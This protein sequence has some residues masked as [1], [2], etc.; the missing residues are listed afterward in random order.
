MDDRGF[1]FTADATLALVIV[2]V[3]TGTMTAYSLLPVYQSNEHQHLEAIASSAL[4]VMEQDGTLNSAAVDT[5]MGNYNSARGNLTNRL[6]ALIP[7]GISYRLSLTDVN[8]LNPPAENDSSGSSFSPNVATKVKV[9]SAPN[10]GWMG[11]AWF[12]V[13]NFTFVTQP[14][15]VTSTVW[16][17]HNWLDKFSPWTGG[18][19]LGTYPYWTGGSAAQ[20]IPFSVPG[21]TFQSAKF[22]VGDDSYS[23]GTAAGG[24]FVLNGGAAIHYN[25]NQSVFVGPRS[26]DANQFIWNYQGNISS[27]NMGATNNFY[28]KSTNMSAHKYD[29][30]WASIIASYST[31]IVVPQGILFNSSAYFPD[32]AGLAVQNPTNLTGGNSNSQYQLLYNLNSGNVTGNTYKRVVDWST[33]YNNDPTDTNGNHYDNG[34]PFVITNANYNGVTDTKTAVSVT[35][36]IPYIAPGNTVLDTFVNVNAYGAVDGALVEVWNGTDWNTIFNSFDI[37]GVDYSAVS[38]GYGNLPGIVYIPSNY[39]V[40]GQ[41]CKVR[42]TVWDDV[43]NGDYDLVGLTKCYITTCYTTLNVGWTDTPFNNHQSAT[44]VETQT[45]QFDIAPDSTQAYLFVGAGMD[46]QNFVVKLNGNNVLY[47]G[48]APYFLDLASLDAAKNFHII[49]TNT[50]TAANYTMNPGTYNLTV[51]VTAPSVETQSGD[52]NAELFSGTRIAVIYPALYNKWYEGYNSTADAAK[53]EAYNALV[54]RLDNELGQGKYDKSK[55]Q[56]QALYVGAL[57]NQATVRLE[58]WE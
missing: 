50:S 38:S 19:G 16:N 29:M 48:S 22:L 51:S 32:A 5:A 31:N 37:D 44:N 45:K 26:N 43:P 15:N 39:V 11:R 14:Q 42:I 40:P 4:E 28:I 57:P 18:N 55:I 20:N 41:N 25:P 30:P 1:I 56:S 13:E 6:N 7:P 34:V 8:T 49:T 9:I 21:G 46:T 24:D 2:I 58:L 47:N 3:L 17:W 53:T 35:Q 23:K 54:Q 27:L 36:N 52:A 12:K 10:Q 33:F